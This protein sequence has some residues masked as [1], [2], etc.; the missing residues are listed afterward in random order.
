MAKKEDKTEKSP[1][2][3][4]PYSQA[5]RAGN[6]IFVSGQIPVDPA[7]GDVVAGPIGGQTRRVL[8]NLRGILEQEGAG[9]DDIVKTTVYLTDLSGFKEMNDVYGEFFKPPYPARET[10]EARALPKGVGVEISA[11]AVV[12]RQGGA[13][14]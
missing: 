9:L 12:E 3:I 2:A 5:I 10:V 4:G 13:K 1:S 6:L 7:T 11:I 14:R 8:E